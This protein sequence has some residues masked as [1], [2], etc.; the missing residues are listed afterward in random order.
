[1]TENVHRALQGKVVVLSE[2]E[3]KQFI[4]AKL[5]N[6]KHEFERV[7]TKWPNRVRV[8]EMFYDLECEIEHGVGR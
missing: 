2:Q 4:R 3:T 8:A 1:M 5:R 6:L 7:S